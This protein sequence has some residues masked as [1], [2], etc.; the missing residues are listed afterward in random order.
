MV[1]VKINKDFKRDFDQYK[2]YI[3]T[4]YG[5]E[6]F[7]INQDGTTNIPDRVVPVEVKEAETVEHL[8]MEAIANIVIEFMHEDSPH[9]RKYKDLC[10]KWRNRDYIVFKRIFCMFARQAGNTV[11]SIG[12]FLDNDHSSVIHQLRQANI[13][14]DASDNFF[15]TRYQLV[16]NKIDNVANISE[17]SNQ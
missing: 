17:D 12:K 11:T 4:V 3:K 9:L 2:N 13:H 14:I 5:V 10:A 16:K 7:Y 15:I 8:S 6:I 1:E